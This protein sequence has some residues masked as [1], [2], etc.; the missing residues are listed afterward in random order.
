VAGVLVEGTFQHNELIEAILGI[1]IN[2]NQ[3]VD[4]LPP[5]PPGAPVPTSLR[6]YSG[7][8]VDRTQL[9]IALC[10]SLSQ[11]LTSALSAQA[12]HA[13]WRS[14]LWTLGQPVSIYPSSDQAEVFRGQAIDVTLEGSLVVED[15]KGTLR[16]FATGDVSVRTF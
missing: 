8:V 11:L 6:L 1:G 12:L 9:L 2:V 7:R 3:T 10:Q 4:A 15:E 14:R 16:V 13:A 5:A